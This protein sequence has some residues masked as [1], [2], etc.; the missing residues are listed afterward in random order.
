MLCLPYAGFLTYDVTHPDSF[1]CH[2]HCCFRDSDTGLTPTDDFRLQTDKVASPGW[3]SMRLTRSASGEGMTERGDV[4]M[5]N[6]D[7]TGGDHSK[8]DIDDQGDQ[9]DQGARSGR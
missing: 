3:L 6:R 4:T 2:D 8:R 7:R 1:N 5:A 9:G